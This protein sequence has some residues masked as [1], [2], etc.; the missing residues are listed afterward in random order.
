MLRRCNWLTLVFILCAFLSFVYKIS[1]LLVVQE[2]FLKLQSD[3]DPIWFHPREQEE[4]FS[5]CLLFKDDNHFLAEWLAYH[6]TSMNLKRLIIATDPL[7]QSSPRAILNRWKSMINITEWEDDDYFNRVFRSGILKDTDL[8]TTMILINLHRQ[9]QKIFYL[10]CMERLKEEKRSWVAFIDTDELLF[11]NY[12]HWKFRNVLKQEQ[13]QTILTLLHRLRK[14]K[15]LSSSP[16]VGIPRI[17][18][19]AREAQDAD[20]PSYPVLSSLPNN[21]SDFMSLRWRWH[22]GHDH[23]LNK[24]GKS[25]L[26]L[27]RVSRDLLEMKNVNAHRPIKQLCTENDMWI[28]VE[29]SPIVLHH[30]VGTSEQWVFRDDVR[31]KRTKDT[32]RGFKMEVNYTKDTT[33]HGWLDDFVHSVGVEQASELLRDAGRVEEKAS[34]GR[35]SPEAKLE[36]LF[37]LLYK[38]KTILPSTITN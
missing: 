24:A 8:N 18:Y 22:A 29:D 20:Q 2:K 23:K 4:E 38:K 5:A 30:Y 17:L 25:L 31:G 16:C 35:M 1:Q 7:S 10:K 11:P 13:N 14:Y 26:D 27:S 19:G 21:V 28:K 33:S 32:Y 6:K 34:S 12:G 36:K 3:Y 37:N 9:R 15:T